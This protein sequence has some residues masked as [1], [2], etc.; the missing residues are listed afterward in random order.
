MNIYILINTIIDKHEIIE[1]A[2]MAIED[3]DILGDIWNITLSDKKNSWRAA[4][5]LDYINELSPRT[6]DLLIPE[7]IKNII[8]INNNSK[9]RHILKI[10]SSRKIDK[11]IAGE[12][13]NF[14][15]DTLIDNKIP[16]A[17][18]VHAMQILADFCFHE[19]DLKNELKYIIEDLTPYNS[20]AFKARAR[21]VLKQL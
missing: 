10:I 21:R 19:P 5:I 16:V 15:F 3:I 1:I 14:C 6:I 4:W 18:R 7:M 8:S 13:I 20:P 12:F 11:N 9:S 2:K 17:V